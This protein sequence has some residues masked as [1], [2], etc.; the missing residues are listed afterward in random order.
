MDLGNEMNRR[1][2]L[3]LLLKSQLFYFGALLLV[4]GLL[5]CSIVDDKK[6]G[7]QIPGSHLGTGRLHYLPLG[8]QTDRDLLLLTGKSGASKGGVLVWD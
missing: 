6:Y 5:I 8:L 4:A 3:K 1:E 2:R 7:A